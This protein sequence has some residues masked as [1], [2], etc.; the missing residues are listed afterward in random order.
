MISR[1]IFVEPEIYIAELQKIF[2]RCWLFLCRRV[3][4][5]RTPLNSQID[6]TASIRRLAPGSATTDAAKA[7][8][9]N[10][11]GTARR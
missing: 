9:V 11:I 2:A 6:M 8:T 4:S 1:R 10:S 5:G 3:I 7:T